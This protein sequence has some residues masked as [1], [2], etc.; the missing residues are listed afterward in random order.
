MTY[1]QYTIYREI[2]GWQRQLVNPDGSIGR[3]LDFSEDDSQIIFQIHD[4]ND[5]WRGEEY[6]LEDARQTID[7]LVAKG[8]VS[9]T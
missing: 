2:H 1:K 4:S 7:E 6:S 8:V 5:V 9:N 3:A